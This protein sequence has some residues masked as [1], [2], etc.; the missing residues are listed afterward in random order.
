[1]A[2]TFSSIPLARTFSG[3]PFQ[4]K[5]EHSDFREY[6][7]GTRIGGGLKFAPAPY[8]PILK[9]DPIL[10][11]GVVIKKGT[12]VTLDSNGFLVPAF[13]GSKSLVYTSVDVEHGVIDID[14]DS[15]VSAQK[16]SI[17]TTKKIGTGATDDVKIGK[18]IGV[19]VQDVFKDYNDPWFTPQKGV[20]ILNHYAVLIGLDTAHQF[21][22]YQVGDLLTLD[23]NG[24][25][26][27][28][29]TTFTVTDSN[30][31]IVKLDDIHFVVGRLIKVIDATKDM[32]TGGLEYV[33]YE[34]AE[35]ATGLPGSQT[36]GIMDGINLQTKKGLLIKLG[37]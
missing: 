8:L 24:F 19:V 7:E 30:P 5:A 14:T 1:M 18:P 9:V 29:D 13:V 11:A 2:R 6:C 22:T 15:A 20:A 26:V 23:L 3:I 28:F 12:F 32:F 16:T 36:G 27:P 34:P 33:E 37:M 31:Q 21:V 17:P 10:N 35:F 25:P 4:Q